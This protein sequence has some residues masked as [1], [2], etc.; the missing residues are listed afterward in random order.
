[1]CWPSCV[2][3]P[4]PNLIESVACTLLFLPP[5]SSDMNPIETF[6]ARFKQ[7]IQETLP[8]L[9]SLQTAVGHV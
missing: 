1:M 2:G 5:D 8:S 4:P 6:W 7:K 3:R 9:K